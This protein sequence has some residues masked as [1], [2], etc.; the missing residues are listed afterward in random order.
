M[1]AP[2][3]SSSPD[4]HQ[5]PPAPANQVFLANATPVHPP[6]SP[7]GNS[8][9]GCSRLTPQDDSFVTPSFG[10]TLPLRQPNVSY[11]V[12]TS[13]TVRVESPSRSDV[14]PSGGIVAQA[15][16]PQ[17]FAGLPTNTN[18]FELLACMQTGQ[19]MYNISNVATLGSHNHHQGMERSYHDQH[20]QQQ[21][22]TPTNNLSPEDRTKMHQ[23]FLRTKR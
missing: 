6:Q 17:G 21:H 18:V 16:V 20:S 1:E 3:H 22:A 13:Q 7:D 8:N 4:G 10:Q 14:A 12:H 5:P 23:E 9:C 19:S 15:T 2:N 11:M